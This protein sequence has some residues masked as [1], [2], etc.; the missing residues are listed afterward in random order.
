MP[1]LGDRLAR[2]PAKPPPIFPPPLSRTPLLLASSAVVVVD[3][4]V[5]AGPFPMVA[6]AAAACEVDRM[7]P[8]RSS[9]EAA[10]PPAGAAVAIDAFGLKLTELEKSPVGLVPS[11]EMPS[12]V[13][14]TMQSTHVGARAGAFLR[15]IVLLNGAPSWLVRGI[16][17]TILDVWLFI[18]G[19][20]LC[21]FNER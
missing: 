21:E 10:V 5:A 13:W 19:N 18:W 17:P 12:R 7:V 15:V 8:P 4:G 14:T 16:T 11:R 3:E 1:R 2:R 9:S 6:V 20:A